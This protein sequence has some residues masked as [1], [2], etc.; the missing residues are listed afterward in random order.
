MAGP[1]PC[2]LLSR[3]VT[4]D[5]GALGRWSV[6]PHRWFSLE[7][8]WRDNKQNISHIP[9][10]EYRLDFIRARRAFS[11]MFDLY[12]I[13]DVP[14]RS[15]VLAHVG[16]YAGDVALAMRTD[17]NG[18]V[19]LGKSHGRIGEKKQRAVFQSQTA[20]REFHEFMQRRPARLIVE[21]VYGHA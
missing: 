16:N 14:E 17:S 10:G 11:G 19:L 15:G 1:A 3:L 13:H 9:V 8:P 7:L 20:V 21:E 5:D 18:C 12:W 6:G 4:G 2:V